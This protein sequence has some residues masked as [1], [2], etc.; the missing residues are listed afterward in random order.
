MYIKMLMEK[1][2]ESEYAQ[3]V[4]PAQRLLRQAAFSCS[5]QRY[6]SWVSSGQSYQ[7]GKQAACTEAGRFYAIRS[8]R[9]SLQGTSICSSYYCLPKLPTRSSEGIESGLT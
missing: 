6:Q 3:V 7:R 8:T 2:L 9:S 1:S 5:S 4:G